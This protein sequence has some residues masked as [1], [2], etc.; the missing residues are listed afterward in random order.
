MGPSLQ[1]TAYNF[2]LIR[3]FNSLGMVTRYLRENPHPPNTLSQ[4][5][6]L[7][8]NHEILRPR[9]RGGNIPFCSPVSSLQFISDEHLLLQKSQ[10]CTLVLSQPRWLKSASGGLLETW[11]LGNGR[12]P[13]HVLA[14]LISKNHRSSVGCRLPCSA[15]SIYILGRE[16]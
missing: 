9:S 16:I 13:S 3:H 2:P 6:L 5:L 15:I 11:F 14:V 10:L 1:L 8:H 7:R 4:I 12:F